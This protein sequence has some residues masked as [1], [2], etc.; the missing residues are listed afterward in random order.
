MAGGI[1]PVQASM[2]SAFGQPKADNPA[3]HKPR[4]GGEAVGPMV[5]GSPLRGVHRHESRDQQ[6][7][8]TCWNALN[9]EPYDQFGRARIAQ[10]YGISKLYAQPLGSSFIQGLIE[11]PNII[12]PGIPFVV[13]TFDTNFS[14]FTLS[15]LADTGGTLSGS[16]SATY[17]GTTI[18]VGQTGTLSFGLLMKVTNVSHTGSGTCTATMTIPWGTGSNQFVQVTMF[19]Q[20][21]AFGQMNATCTANINDGTHNVQLPLGVTTSTATTGTE[22]DIS[23]TM[24]YHY[25]TVVAGNNTLQLLGSTTKPGPIVTPFPTTPAPLNIYTPNGINY[26]VNVSSLVPVVAMTIAGTT[27]PASTFTVTEL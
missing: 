8:G 24:V 25:D 2:L 18:V 10:R 6:P 4:P 20:S 14:N 7:E 12:Y 3:V 11:V 15:G 26:A 16:G 1:D 23:A 27:T 13:E 9:I 19:V 22:V 21:L 17:S 5:I